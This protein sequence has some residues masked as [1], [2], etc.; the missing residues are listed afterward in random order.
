MLSLWHAEDANMEL[1]EEDANM[2]LSEGKR[3]SR[4]SS[5][6]SRSPESTATGTVLSARRSRFFA[7]GSRRARQLLRGEER[8]RTT[9]AFS[10]QLSNSE[11]TV[12]YQ[13]STF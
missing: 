10:A 12:L 2:E 8:S 6:R 1:S 9:L 11:R 4:A 3:R 5:S 13:T 7:S